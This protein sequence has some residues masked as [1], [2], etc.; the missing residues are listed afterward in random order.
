MI[1]SAASPSFAIP[2]PFAVLFSFPCAKLSLEA[3]G[4]NSKINYK[5]KNKL[6]AKK[7]KTEISPVN[8]RNWKFNQSIYNL[9]QPCLLGCSLALLPLAFSFHSWSQYYLYQM[10]LSFLLNLIQWNGEH[11]MLRCRGCFLFTKKASI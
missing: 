11:H 1:V 9:P 7:P 6:H 2:F 8:H 5:I 10:S 4:C 3:T